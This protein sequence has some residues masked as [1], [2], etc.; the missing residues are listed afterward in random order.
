MH[1]IPSYV[2]RGVF[3]ILFVFGSLL[4]CSHTG[5]HPWEGLARLG[6]MRGRTVK[7]LIFGNLATVL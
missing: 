1:K 5:N 3:F 2:S 4:L 7:V 6:Y